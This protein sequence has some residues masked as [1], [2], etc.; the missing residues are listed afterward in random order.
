MGARH[1]E[2]GMCKVSEEIGHDESRVQE[3]GSLLNQRGVA[4]SSM[5]GIYFLLKDLNVSHRKD[6]VMHI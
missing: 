2:T 4:F 3:E 1:V 6:E 5:K